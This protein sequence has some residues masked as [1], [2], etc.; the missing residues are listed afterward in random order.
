MNDFEC[1]K[2]G[3]CCMNLNKS[4]LYDDLNDGTGVCIFFDKINK[5]CKIYETRPLKC[6]VK[7]A[8][9]KLFKY[10]MPYEEYLQLNYEMC[11][12]LKEK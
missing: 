10:Y 9:K 8:Y 6:N 5:L 11:K 12:K 7:L 4:S 3:L 1:D 2:C